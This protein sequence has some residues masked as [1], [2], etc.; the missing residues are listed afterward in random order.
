MRLV[1]QLVETGAERSET[2]GRGIDILEL[3]RP[4]DLREI[5][6]FGLILAEAK[7]LLTRVQQVL[8]DL[9]PW[10]GR[11]KAGSV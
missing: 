10:P 11:C 5:A 4:R 3:D 7:Q 8:S 6:N 1:L 9:A 2:R